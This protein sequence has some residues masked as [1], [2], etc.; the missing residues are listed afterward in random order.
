MTLEVSNISFTSTAKKKEKTCKKTNKG[1]NIASGIGFITGGLLSHTNFYQRNLDAIIL[2]NNFLCK[3][4]VRVNIATY[5]LNG[6]T[7][8]AGGLIGRGIGAIIDSR[9]NKRNQAKV[10]KLA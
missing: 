5:L 2:K 4:I 9:I 1:K 6:L 8:L 3:S 10:D 7:I